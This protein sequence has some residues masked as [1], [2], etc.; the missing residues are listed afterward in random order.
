MR[1]LLDHLYTA[2]GVLAAVFLFGIFVIVLA[3]V[4][5]NILDF[6]IAAV[7]GTAVGLVVPSYTEF[8]GF[9]LA[10]SSFLALAHTFR[11]GAHIRVSLLLQGLPPGPRKIADLFSCLVG[12]AVC[13]YFAW[14]SWLLVI[15]SIDFKDVSPGLVPIPL[16]IPQSS[17]AIGVTVLAI[18]IADT[19]VRLMIDG[20]DIACESAGEG[21][22]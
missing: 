2:S 14:Y 15:D 21:A 13:A 4:G 5:A 7:T 18:A 22:E 9:F 19:A 17:M 11:N 12:M 20:S 6:M 10:A 16:W 3:Q 1:K 8:A